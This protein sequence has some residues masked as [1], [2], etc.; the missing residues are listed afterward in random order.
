MREDGVCALTEG[1]INEVGKS[2]QDVINGSS[3]TI[4]DILLEV[5]LDGTVAA[6]SDR[7]GEQTLAVISLSALVKCKGQDLI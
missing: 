7:A 6:Y 2:D 5:R 1:F 3:G 4:K